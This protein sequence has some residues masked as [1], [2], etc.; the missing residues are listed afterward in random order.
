MTVLTIDVAAESDADRRML[1]MAGR[2]TLEVVD[3]FDDAPARPALVDLA[4]GLID[5]A[6]GEE[7]RDLRAW[8]ADTRA[9]VERGGER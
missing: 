3:T 9:Q 8:L 4:A 7:A 5:A 2:Y 1:L 6:G